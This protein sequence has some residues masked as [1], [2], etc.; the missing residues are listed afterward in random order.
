M[1]ETFFLCVYSR[2]N[3]TADTVMGVYV[4]THIAII[5]Y[6]LVDKI[7]TIWMHVNI[8]IEVCV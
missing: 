1:T 5:I 7:Y 4:C 8:A 6:A 3:F 2:D